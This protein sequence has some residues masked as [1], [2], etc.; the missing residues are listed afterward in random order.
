M[1]K[2]VV[3]FNALA[4][5]YRLQKCHFI[6]NT[7]LFSWCA[8]RGADISISP[9]CRNIERKREEGWEGGREDGREG[10]KEKKLSCLS[11][12]FIGDV[13]ILLADLLK[14]IIILLCRQLF[15]AFLR[16][17]KY[18]YIFLKLST[19]ISVREH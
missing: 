10:E 2:K 5:I 6:C 8:F 14:P 16:Y 12:P 1:E 9:E 7:Y 19:L 3:S 18:G 11:F 15:E 4:I 17:W 13:K